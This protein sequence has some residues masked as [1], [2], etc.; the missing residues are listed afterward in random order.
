M[1]LQI[2]NWGKITLLVLIGIRTPFITIGSGPT[3][4]LM[5]SIVLLSSPT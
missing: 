1:V 5:F 3:L 2:G 4:Y